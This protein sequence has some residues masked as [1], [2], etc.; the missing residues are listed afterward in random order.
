MAEGSTYRIKF[1]NT[2]PA[3][4]NK[5]AADLKS[6]LRNE[7]PQQDQL[8]IDRERTSPDS[9]DFG[10]TPVL[11]LGT[12]AITAVARGL[13]KWLTAHNGTRIE[14]ITKHGK[15][16]ATNVDPKSTADITK[17]LQNAEADK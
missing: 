4:A 10:A 15:V 12:T 16:I 9:Q 8:S 5:K 14:I 2:T 1:L 7:V 3:E 11:V 6:W 13:E 17:A